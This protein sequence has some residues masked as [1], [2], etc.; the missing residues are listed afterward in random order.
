MGNPPARPP[1]RSGVGC[2][3]LLYIFTSLAAFL[4]REPHEGGPTGLCRDCGYDLAG[5][6]ERALCPECGSAVREFTPGWSE[7]VLRPHALPAWSITLAVMLLCLLE[8]HWVQAA[9]DL[10]WRVSMGNWHS[11]PSDTP[12]E[13]VATAAAFAPLLG[14]LRSR[15]AAV[16]ATLTVLLLAYLLAV[17]VTLR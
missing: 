11:L 9:I 12:T 14:R 10:P 17:W 6:D 4:G 3:L 1:V 8:P 15:T 7:L 5:L 16:V 2:F 13:L